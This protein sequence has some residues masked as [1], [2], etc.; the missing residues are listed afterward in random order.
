MY[1]VSP[2]GLVSVSS[3]GSFSSAGSS[4]R[5]SYYSFTLSLLALHAQEYFNKK[6]GRKKKITIKT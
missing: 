5:P 1:V 6:R 2:H 4:S 3:I